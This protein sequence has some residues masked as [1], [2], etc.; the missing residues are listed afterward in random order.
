MS[1]MEL[2]HSPSLDPDTKPDSKLPAGVVLSGKLLHGLR[3]SEKKEQSCA[4]RKL[5]RASGQVA[6]NIRTCRS[7]RTCMGQAS[8]VRRRHLL[9]WKSITSTSDLTFSL[10][11]LLFHVMPAQD[12]KSGD[13]GNLH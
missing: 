11:S 10:H 2:M 5:Y 1:K 7:L 4:G 12:Y 3:N 13:S 6:L 8:Q 9:M